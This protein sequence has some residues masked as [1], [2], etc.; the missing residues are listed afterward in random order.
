MTIGSTKRD[1]LIAGNHPLAAKE[2]TITGPAEFRRGDVVGAITAGGY[3]LANSTATNGSQ[4]AIG[5]ITD[6]IVVET[7]VNIVT[8][9]YVK[10]EFNQRQLRFGGSDTV[11]NHRRRMTEIGLLIRETRI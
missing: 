1:G 6:D 9:M 10:G 5:I 4:N 11:E 8:T 7:G 3:A 2:I